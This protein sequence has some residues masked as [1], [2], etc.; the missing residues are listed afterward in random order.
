MITYL[1]EIPECCS[2]AGSS[3]SES[4]RYMVVTWNNLHLILQNMSIVNIYPEDKIRTY[5][6]QNLKF[7]DSATYGR[8]LA[9]CMFFFSEFLPSPLVDH[10]REV[11]T[12][13]ESHIWKAT[14]WKEHKIPYSVSSLRPIYSLFTLTNVT[15]KDMWKIEII[16][17]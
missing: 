14:S 9:Y 5:C 8:I 12:M 7:Q 3:C 6:F 13:K 4:S 1:F 16:I 10:V 17:K 2:L 15:N 11:A